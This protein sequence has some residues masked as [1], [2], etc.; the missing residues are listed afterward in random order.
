MLMKILSHAHVK[1]KRKK[2]VLKISNFTLN[3][4]FLRKKKKKRE[5][6]RLTREKKKRSVR[7][8]LVDNQCVTQVAKGPGRFDLDVDAGHAN[9]LQD[10]V[11][12]IG[13]K[14]HVLQISQNLGTFQHH[15]STQQ[16]NQWTKPNQPITK[17]K[18]KKKVSPTNKLT[19]NKTSH[20][21]DLPWFA[22]N[23]KRLMKEA[24]AVSQ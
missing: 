18:R 3:W 20:G 15:A 5:C 10:G 11:G 21:S 19:K 2:K 16:T 8:W 12:C 24:R 9:A 23:T 13:H 6:E 22:R 4:S 17:R 14:Y 7:N 1:E